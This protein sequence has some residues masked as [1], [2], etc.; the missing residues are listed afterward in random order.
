MIF[1]V[2]LRSPKT[3][4]NWDDVSALCNS[5]LNSLLQQTSSNFKIIL[6]CNELPLNFQAHEKV[7]TIV[8]EF[9]IPNTWE[10]GIGDIYRKIKRAMIDANQFGASFIMRVDADDLVSKYLVEYTDKHQNC[11]GWYLRWGYMYPIG[12]DYI[13]LR[14]KFTTI[15]GSSNI[16]K[17]ED[18]EF[19]SSLDTASKD[20][21]EP[22]WQHLNINT[23]LVPYNKKLKPLPFPGVVFRTHSANMSGS[24]LN[25]GR[26]SNLKN[27]ILKKVFCRKLSPKLIDNFKI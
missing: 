5:T 16:L 12:E 9:P 1:I 22:V 15:S 10:E 3:C 11:D 26:F 24:N 18:N 4:S 8:E 14:P 19:P 6:C 17:C 13:Y 21:L 7:M 27:I 23:L 2:P 20:W 25:S